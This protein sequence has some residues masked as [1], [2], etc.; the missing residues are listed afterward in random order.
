MTEISTEQNLSFKGNVKLLKSLTM[1]QLKEKLDMSYLKSFRRTLFKIVWLLIEFAA[2]TA[3]C[4][5]LLYFF[6][7]KGV[8]SLI[9]DIP[10]SVIAIVYGIMLTLS[11]LSTT[12]GLVNSLYFSRDNQVLLTLP[13]ESW[14]IF[15]SKL[16]VYYIYELRKSV[17][18]IMPVFV[19]YGIV[20]HFAW[21]YYLWVAALF[22]F[23]S[24]LPVAVSALLSMPAMYAYQLVKKAQ[25]LQYTLIA[26]GLGALTFVAVKLINLIPDNIDIV[27]SWGT[28]YWKIQAGLDWFTK[29][30]TVLYGLT[31]L[32]VGKRYGFT[33]KLFTLSTLWSF[34]ILIA[35]IAVCITLC[36]L[37]AR[38]LFYKMA[39]KPFEYTK[40]TNVKRQDNKPCGKFL[41]AVK[42]E[43]LIGMRDN[44]LISLFCLL[45]I[46][47]PVAIMLLNKI[48]SAMNTRL[49]GTQ[50]TVGFNYL[51]IM[52]VMLQSNISV[53]SV[54]SRDGSAAYLNKIQPTGY[55]PL[56]LSKLV[57]NLLIGLLGVIVTFVSYGLFKPLNVGSIIL[58]AVSVY[59]VY[60]CHLFW[61][62]ETDVMNPQHEQYATFNSQSNN[63]NENISALL[64]FILAAVMFVIAL[65]L[66]MESMTKAWIKVSILSVVLAAAKAF[67]FFLKVKMFYKE[68]Q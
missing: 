11:V 45:V 8:F 26:L 19:A 37:L 40:K 9:N 31:T 14:L 50:L 12:I 65:L 66:S 61:S 39:S 23:L 41:T 52:L 47:L 1:M 30:M 33:Q 28:I 55:A 43:F 59:S 2:V 46:V 16:A 3:I 36:M 18:Y 44:S 7:V 63:P 10:V 32:I 20:Q 13:A 15:V 49:L 57:F 29:H 56:L 6:K 58:M 54:Y 5:L 53:A 67:T 27:K 68:K 24:V 34:L 60:V 42:K 62:A 4:F 17:M 25:W 64:M 22:V 38:P 48:Y 35:V 51:L 21:F